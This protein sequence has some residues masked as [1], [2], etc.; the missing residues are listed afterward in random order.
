MDLHVLMMPAE[1]VECEG[2]RIYDGVRLLHGPASPTS[3]VLDQDGTEED[4][5]VRDQS[6]GQ[7][8]VKQ[9]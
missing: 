2:I 7:I 3:L 8:D 5:R 6:V 1:Y 4:E 9:Y